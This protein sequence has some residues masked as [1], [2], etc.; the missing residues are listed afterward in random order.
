MLEYGAEPELVP[1]V[2]PEVCPEVLL[3]VSVSEGTCHIW[4]EGTTK[5]QLCYRCLPYVT[6]MA[7]ETLI[8]MV[9]T[10]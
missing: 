4:Q 7:A 2:C 9:F 8:P 3:Y 6:G 1:E 10:L 5:L